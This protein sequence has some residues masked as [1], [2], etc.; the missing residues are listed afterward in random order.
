MN[1]EARKQISLAGETAYS[2][3]ALADALGYQAKTM[4]QWRR[5]GKLKCVKIGRHWYVV[6]E[7]AKRLVREGT[8]HDNQSTALYEGTD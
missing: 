4:D 1:T 5:E 6:E 8:G 3:Q 2:L 7:E